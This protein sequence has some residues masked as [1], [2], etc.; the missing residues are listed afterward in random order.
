MTVVHVTD[1]L[2]GQKLDEIQTNYGL[3]EIT[4]THCTEDNSTIMYQ[5]SIYVPANRA[6]HVQFIQNHYDRAFAGLLE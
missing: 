6:L 4:V 1:P 5:G 2:S 3:K